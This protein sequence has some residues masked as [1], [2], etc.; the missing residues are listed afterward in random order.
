MRSV[1]EWIAKH[2]DQKVP[3]HVRARIF[4]R[5]G[6]RCHLSGRPIRPG[7]LWD[8]DHDPALW[9]GGEH[10]ESQL[11]PVLRDK[12]K[13]KSAAERTEKTKEDRQRLSHLGLKP[14]G[15]GWSRKLRRKLDGTVEARDA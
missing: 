9:K 1:E 15:R 7:D 6:G 2:D 4:L 10:R 12:H 11:F 8:L 13:V 3:P 14:K 5:E